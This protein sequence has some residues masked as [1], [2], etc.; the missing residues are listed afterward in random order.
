ML[1]QTKYIAVLIPIIVLVII[2]GVILIKVIKNDGSFELWRI[3]FAFFGLLL[4]CLLAFFFIKK[5]M[6]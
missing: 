5:L 1:K 3:L 4:T 6:I 2:S